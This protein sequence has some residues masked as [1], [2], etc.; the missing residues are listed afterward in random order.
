ME[1]WNTVNFNFNKRK[2]GLI[3]RAP[4]LYN[5]NLKPTFVILCN[6]NLLIQEFIETL[7][8]F[9]NSTGLT[10]KP[11]AFFN[12]GYILKI[13]KEPTHWHRVCAPSMYNTLALSLCANYYSVQ[14]RK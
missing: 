4:T 1:A 5:I 7:I 11:F 6:L 13:N 2:Y 10:V 14:Q 8:W 12:C 3:F 9:A